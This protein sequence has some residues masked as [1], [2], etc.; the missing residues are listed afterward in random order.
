VQGDKQL[1]LA[2]VKLTHDMIIP[3][4]LIKILAHASLQ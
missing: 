1:I 2:R 4:F 3:H